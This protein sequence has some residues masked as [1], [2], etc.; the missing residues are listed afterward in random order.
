MNAVSGSLA[1]DAGVGSM[2]IVVTRPG[3]IFSRS[4]VVR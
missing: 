1:A 3:G 4:S 2:V